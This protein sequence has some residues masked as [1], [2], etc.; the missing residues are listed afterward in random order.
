MP[1]LWLL[2]LMGFIVVVVLTTLVLALSPDTFVRFSGHSMWLAKSGVAQ[3]TSGQQLYFV[4]VNN[5]NGGLADGTFEHPYPTLV[6]AQTH[7]APGNVIYCFAGDGT[8]AGMNAG[9][10]MKNTQSLLGSGVAQSVSTSRGNIVVPALSVGG[11]SISSPAD[12][13]TLASDNI[14]SGVTITEAV[15]RG[16]SGSNPHNVCIKNCVVDSSQDDQISLQY[17]ASSSAGALLFNNVSFTQGSNGI[18]VQSSTL[19][20]Q[21][22]QIT[23]C[24]FQQTAVDAVNVSFSGSANVVFV[25]NTLAANY[26]GARFVCAGAT[27]ALSVSGNTFSE[28]SSVSEFPLHI[29]AGSNP[30]S[31]TIENNSFTNNVTGCIRL[32]LTDTDTAA[33]SILSNTFTDNGSGSLASLGSVM[34]VNPNNSSSGSCSLTLEGNTISHNNKSAVYCSNGSFDVFSVNASNNQINDNGAGLVFDIAATAFSLTAANNVI[35]NND[36]NGIVTAGGRTMVTTSIKLDSNVIT[37]NAAG[38][39]LS[40]DC[41]T[42]RFSTTNNT[43]SGNSGSGIILYSSGFIA[44]ATVLVENNTISNNQNSDSNQAGGLDVEQFTQ[45]CMQVNNNVLNDDVSAAMYVGSTDAVSA[46]CVQMS[47]NQTNVEYI[48]DN[49]GGGGLNLAPTNASSVNTGSF[50]L[51]GVITPVSA[52]DCS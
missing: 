20:A 35:R 3:N 7:S 1:A 34:V 27:S 40:S 39:A 38:V 21:T 17:D 19:G 48:L 30:V 47:V 24:T 18:A 16:I 13:I 51:F 8:T 33:V 37:N 45:L 42:L 5:T 41:S 26:S 43:I 11:P 44:N 12:G 50:V 15:G 6:L 52:C 10:V 14:I 49:S 4:F 36:D 23:N 32:L 2:V 28:T 29:E 22:L 46:A 9:L 31:A 25:G